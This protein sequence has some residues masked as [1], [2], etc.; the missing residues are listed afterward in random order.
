MIP[1]AIKT[2]MDD[3]GRLTQ[4]PSKRSQQLVALEYLASKIAPD[5]HY[6]ERE[7]N[8]LLNLWHSFGDPALLRRELFELGYVNR[9]RN[10]SAY[11]R[12]PNTKLYE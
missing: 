3:A 5:K 10:G 11:W 2:F 6:T 9:E 4:W 1:D 8:E 12:T 7:I